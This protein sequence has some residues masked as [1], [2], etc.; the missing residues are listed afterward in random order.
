VIVGVQIQTTR[1]KRWF[2]NDL[3]AAFAVSIVTESSCDIGL[4]GALNVVRRPTYRSPLRQEHQRSRRLVSASAGAKR[5][6]TCRTVPVFPDHSYISDLSF[7]DDG[8]RHYLQTDDEDDDLP[9]DGPEYDEDSDDDDDL[10]RW[11]EETTLVAELLKEEYVTF[12]THIC[13]L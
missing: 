12:I 6:R 2:V 11:E 7:A 3:P 10:F 1:L 9:D 8:T 4:T 13:A 5:N